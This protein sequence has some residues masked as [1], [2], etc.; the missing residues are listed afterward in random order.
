MIKK[1]VKVVQTHAKKVTGITSE[2]SRLL[3]FQPCEKEDRKIEKDI[4]GSWCCMIR[5][6]D[7]SLRDKTYVVVIIVPLDKLS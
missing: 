1:S 6:T 3:G 2:E 4:G 5:V 7:L